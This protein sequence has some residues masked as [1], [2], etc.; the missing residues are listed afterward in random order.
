ME[1]PVPIVFIVDDD[2]SVRESLEL[3][4]A[5]VGWQPKTFASAQMFLAY[6]R[7]FVPNCLVLDV[8]LPDLNGLDLQ[9]LIGA[10]RAD[11][12][13]VFITGN[14]DV[15]MTVQA[16]KAG[17]VDFLTKPFSDEALLSA[18]TH[19]IVRS[20]AALADEA[21][22][23]ELREGYKS[24]TPREREVMAFVVAGRLNKQVGGELGISEIT[25]K[26]HRGNVMRKMKAASLPEL[27]IMA[28]RLHLAVESKR[29]VSKSLS[30]Q[31][32]SQGLFKGGVRVYRDD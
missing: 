21:Q 9:R 10:K 6:P 32:C 28:A 22:L 5:S 30:L 27:V 3:L 17:A 18:I 26:A 29:R 2:I 20:A 1:K 13:I 16:M 11:M 25:V 8:S 23:C 14:G 15:P 4:I 7:V 12:P 19:A 24:L 31:S